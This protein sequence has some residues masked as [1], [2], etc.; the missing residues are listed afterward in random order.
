MSWVFVSNH[1]NLQ[2]WLRT[3]REHLDPQG[4]WRVSDPGVLVEFT[5]GY[6]ETDDPKIAEALQKHPLC[7]V[8]FK[9]FDGKPI[10]EADLKKSALDTAVPH[11]PVGDL[12]PKE[13]KKFRCKICGYEAKSPYHLRLHK[14]EAHPETIG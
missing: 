5:G 13:K 9:P 6:Y 11:P 10:K 2:L 12:L 1:K 8:T 3:P 7:N 4:R 14:E